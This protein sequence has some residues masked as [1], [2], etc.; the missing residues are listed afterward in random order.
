M[1]QIKINNCNNIKKGE[2]KLEPNKLNIKYGINGTGK[3]TIAKAIKFS[4]DAAKLQTLKSYY[5]DDDASISI[6]PVFQKILVFDEEFVN[7]V[8]FKEDEVIENT[9]EIFLKTPNYEQ[10]REQLNRHLQSL[11][12][13]LSAD[14]KII[15]LRECLLKINEKFKR[16]ATGKLSATGAMKSLLS[17]QIYTI[18]HRN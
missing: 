7:Q 12:E 16:T 1:Y 10:K 8:V 18:Y 11:K 13:I 2:I 3:T 17:K 4:D 15:S 9:F 14:S 5:A 6:S